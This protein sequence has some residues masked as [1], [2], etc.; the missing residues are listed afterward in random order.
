MPRQAFSRRSLLA[1]GLGSLAAFGT[2]P[3]IVGQEPKL[4]AEPKKDET[5]KPYSETF[6]S[7]TL[8]L[9]YAGDPCTSVTVQW[10][11]SD[12]ESRAKELLFAEF[13]AEYEKARDRAAKIKAAKAMMPVDPP[14]DEDPKKDEPKKEEPKPKEDPLPN[15]EWQKATISSKPFPE[16]DLKVFR[17]ELTGLKAGTEYA[18]KVGTY[19]PEFRFRT[20]PAK[21]TDTFTFISGGDCGI[22]EHAVANNR[23]AAKQ[24]PYFVLICGDL[25]YDNGRSAR[26]AIQFIKNY[27]KT[28]FD[29]KG[30]LIPLVV[31]IGNHEV[32]GGYS[33]KRKDATFFL[34]LFDGLFKETTYGTLDFGQYL[35]LVILDSGHVCKI[36]GDQTDWLEKQLKDRQDIPHLFAANHVPAYPSYREPMG[37]GGKFGTGEEQRK[38]W[39]PL[40][41]KYAVDA[42]LE[43]HDHTFKRTHLLL[44]GLKDDRGVLY[45]G[46][47]S[48]GMLRVPKTP[49]KRPYLAAV[50]GSY[51]FTVH[52]LE[53]E[54]RYHV[55]MEEGGKLIDITSSTKKSRSKLKG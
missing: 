26:T 35:S 49:E 32:N 44:D 24:D 29:S 37:K 7:E 38:H 43:H 47:G 30:R 25:G 16:T 23:L 6:S 42:V 53:S 28:M 55:A 4:P 36:S 10:I 31:G 41:E 3:L 22:N 51:H 34:P 45:L 13:T 48:W 15:L 11:A 8:F 12:W 17:V 2:V 50:G 20:M 5:P 1:A 46:D 9:T 54:I 21:A 52:K 19:S 18:F 39:C 33:T 14:K 27:A 40:F